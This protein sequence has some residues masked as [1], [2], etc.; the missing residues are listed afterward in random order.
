MK[1]ILTVMLCPI[2]VKAFAQ[3]ELMKRILQDI[4]N[5]LQIMF[6]RRIILDPLVQLEPT[7]IA[8]MLK[9]SITKNNLRYKFFV[10]MACHS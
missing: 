6:I 3:H 10:R 7:G 4:K 2:N 9:R 1:N 5:G 8:N